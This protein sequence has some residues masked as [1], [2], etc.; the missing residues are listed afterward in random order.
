MEAAGVPRR[1]TFGEDEN[2]ERT[3]S[4]G[5]GKGYE[6]W[7]GGVEEGEEEIKDGGERGE[8]GVG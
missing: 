4:V 6:D 2:G 8:E 3:I 7:G 5:G 1:R